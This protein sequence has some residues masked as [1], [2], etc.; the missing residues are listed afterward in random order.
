MA[1]AWP[2][3]SAVEIARAVHAREV[4]AVEVT[5]AHLERIARLDGR[6]GAFLRVDEPGA[7]AQAAAVDGALAAGRDP[8]PLAGVP[9][10]LKDLF[11]T[12][13]L[14]TTAGS[15]ILAGWIPPYDGTAVARLREA[16][17]I[18][19]GKLNMDE[20]AMGSSNENSAFGPCRN[21]WDLSRVP[22]GSSGGSAAAVA[23]GL[24][25]IALGTDTGGS[26]RQPASLSGCVGLKPTYGRV[27]RYGVVAFA[28]SLDQVGPFGRT[29]ED[30]AL[31]LEAIA[32][33]DPLDA[34]SVDAPVPRYRDQCGAAASDIRGLRVG[35][36]EEFFAAG[37]DAG[38]EKLV[39][40]A[41]AKLEALGAGIVPVSLPH[42]EYAVAT[43]YLV[44]TAEASSNLARYD[45]VRYGLRASGADLN[46]MYCRTRAAGF[47]DE[48]KRR[49][50]LGTYALRAGYYDAY[51]LRAQKVRALIRKDF[52][53]AFAGCDVI[54]TPTSPVAAFKLGE[55][56]SDPLAMYLA[57]IYTISCNLA[58][59]P[60]LSVP[61]GLL[62]GRLPVGV[63]L[64]G[65]P[66]DEGTLLRVAAAY[67][68]ATD[69]HTRRPPIDSAGD[70]AGDASLDGD[71]A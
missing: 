59:I 70:S 54:A 27:S 69:F 3:R 46:D 68:R 41:I 28:S 61:C 67:Q 2:F 33:H 29:A 26:I 5:R 4:S 53:D 52:T 1:E 37:L 36:P 10:G 56:T 30:V 40:A 16:G 71:A 45:G 58:G 65:R 64:L 31:A 24:C 19:V 23:A 14:E 15:K 17:A 9:V 60:G 25:A 18:L 39:R 47:G 38:V 6:L 13:G 62:D 66:L 44:A 7:L 34:T 42:T 50:M 63:Q 32:G 48:V 20:F 49:I 12:R 35:V 21:P 11:V 43:Y 8:G 55:R 51:Y 57:D 22:G